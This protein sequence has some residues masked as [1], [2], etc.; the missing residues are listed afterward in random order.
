MNQEGKASAE[1]VVLTIRVSLC[2]KDVFQVM[3]YN[4]HSA[5]EI[6]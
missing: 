3:H 6:V 5:E 2:T 4:L 1:L